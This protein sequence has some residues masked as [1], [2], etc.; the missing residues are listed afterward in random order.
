ME[1]LQPWKETVDEL[2]Y[3]IH[4]ETKIRLMKS[5]CMERECPIGDLI[6][7][8]FAHEFIRLAEDDAW[9]YASIAFINADGV[10]SDIH[11]GSNY[12]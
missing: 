9:T 6:A 3:K 11:V 4:G 10:R 5:P 12:S 8:S 7:D 1:Q 2:S